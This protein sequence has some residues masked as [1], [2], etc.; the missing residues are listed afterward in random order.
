M[1]IIKHKDIYDD[2]KSPFENLKKDLANLQSQI[3]KLTQENIKLSNSLQ[4]VKK[5]GD[6]EEAK[7]LTKLTND[8]A[9]STAKLNTLKTEEARKLSELKVKQSELNKKNREAA[10]ERLGLVDAYQ[11]ESKKLNELRKAY[12]NLAIQNKANTKEGKALLKNLQSLDKKLKDVDK[13]VGQSQRNV[14]NYSGALKGFGLQILGTLGLMGGLQGAF[15]G[16]KNIIGATAEGQLFLAKVSGATNTVLATFR[17]E[18]IDAWGGLIKFNDELRNSDSVLEILGNS[19]LEFYK[20]RGRGLL[21][22]FTSFADAAK[23]NFSDA[24]KNMQDGFVQMTLGIEDATEKTQ[25]FIEKTKMMAAFGAAIA[26]SEKK[27]ELARSEF[28]IR[29]AKDLRRIADLRQKAADKSNYSAKERQK[30]LEQALYLTKQLGKE[31]ELFAKRELALQQAV[32]NANKSNI[33]EE[34]KLNELKRK[35]DEVAASNLKKQKLLV[36]ELQTAKREA[37]QE[38]LLRETTN[39]ETISAKKVQLSTETEKNITDIVKQEQETRTAIIKEEQEK[40]LE[41]YKQLEQTKKEIAETALNE[42]IQLT[43]DIFNSYQDDKLNKIQTDAETEKQILKQRL[44]DGLISEK[45]YKDEIAKI[46]KK[47]R[48]ENAKAQK[49]ESIFGIAIDTAVAVIKTLA[50]YGFTPAGWAAAAAMTALG[51]VQAAAVAAKPIP[52][53][54]E[55]E[56]DINGKSHSEGGI[57]AEIEGGE[58][59]INKSATQQSKDLLTAI[60]NGL[61]TDKDFKTQKYDA[62]LMLAGLLMSGNNINKQ[63]LDAILNTVSTYDRGNERIVIYPN[64]KIEKFKI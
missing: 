27:L 8:L 60:N 59:V 26:E 28:A 14:G 54:A 30:F 21:K 33:D 53:F 51:G 29:E 17:D 20:V 31:N 38:E 44:D 49:K 41:A 37:A 34:I 16:L 64:G 3:S 40:Q 47:V 18:I 23:G 24:V 12:K 50:K 56:I 52:K 19:F 39:L 45:Q 42:T 22:F 46:D 43:K 1:A 4:T 13:S 55:G 57:L 61:I 6:G 7:Q 63:M 10:K 25:D 2:S 36:S 15:T 48:T 9:K 35:A 5:S 58:S 62:N 32:F 11:R